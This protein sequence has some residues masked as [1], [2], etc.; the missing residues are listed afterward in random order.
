MYQDIYKSLTK[1]ASDERLRKLAALIGANRV[2]GLLPP[3]A[4]A[5][6]KMVRPLAA[7]FNGQKPAGVDY[8]KALKQLGI[9]TGVGA[10]ML[11]TGYALRGDSGAKELQSRL[12]SVEAARD[13]SAKEN[14]AL[15]APSWVMSGML[16]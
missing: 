5:G 15:K 6:K 11:G 3:P 14:A 2:I 12:G 10:G 16:S 7:S 13:K 1:K 9:G 8:K 4:A